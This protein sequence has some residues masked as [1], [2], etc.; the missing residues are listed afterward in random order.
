MAEAAA[1]AEGKSPAPAEGESPAPAEAPASAEAPAAAPAP[2]P[3]EAPAAATN[4]APARAGGATDG[5][6][7]AR[8]ASESTAA[9]ARGGTVGDREDLPPP[10]EHDSH[11][12]HVVLSAKLTAAPPRKAKVDGADGEKKEITLTFGLLHGRLVLYLSVPVFRRE[13]YSD[14]LRMTVLRYASWSPPLRTS[15]HA[16]SSGCRRR[17]RSPWRWI[18]GSTSPP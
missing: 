12:R 1:P 6:P 16:A 15:A 10:D 13:K 3:A 11:R 14:G 4:E 17:S 5:S 8:I 7:E 2:A 18:G 9:S